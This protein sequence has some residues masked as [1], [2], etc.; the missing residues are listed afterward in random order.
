[1]GVP[2]VWY[3]GGYTGWVI[4]GHGTHRPAARKEQTYQRSG[5]RRPCRGRSGWVGAAG[6]SELLTHPSGPVGHPRCPPWSG[7]LLGQSNGRA[8]HQKARLRSK[9]CK[10]SQNDEVSPKY[11][12]KA[13]VTPYFQNGSE[14][15]LLKFWDFRKR[16]PSLPR[17]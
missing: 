7:P 14:S 13:S 9:Y 16:Q 4:P 5:P 11:V 15:H 10:V 3:Q 1:M 8:N 2:G 17:N 12:N 6:A